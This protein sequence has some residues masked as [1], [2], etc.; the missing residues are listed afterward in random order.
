MIRRLSGRLVVV[1]CGI[2]RFAD[3]G[4]RG[5][6]SFARSRRRRRRRNILREFTRR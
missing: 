1:G 2:A 5:R 4:R 6:R 3:N